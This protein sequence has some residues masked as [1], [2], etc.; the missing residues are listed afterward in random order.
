MCK[1]NPVC[2]QGLSKSA[3]TGQAATIP[4]LASAAGDM[5]PI[6]MTTI[7]TLNDEIARLKKENEHLRQMAAEKAKDDESG[8]SDD[9]GT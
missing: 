3:A 7:A 6:L 2:C 5:T 8:A 1:N 4:G 9:D